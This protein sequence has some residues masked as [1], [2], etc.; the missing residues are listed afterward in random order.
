RLLPAE[1]NED[2]PEVVGVLLHPVVER[3]D[4]LAVEEAQDVLLQ[5]PRTLAGDDLDQRRLLGDSLVDD[6]LECLVDLAAT[7]VDVVEFELQ[8]HPASG[9]AAV[10]STSTSWPG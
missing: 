6:R 9:S 8:L 1:V 10:T 7:V 5:L 4:V 2:A 3:L